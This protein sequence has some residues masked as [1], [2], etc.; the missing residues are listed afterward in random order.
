MSD[1]YG[2]PKPEPKHKRPPT[3]LKA[4]RRRKPKVSI[5]GLAPLTDWKE[6]T[7]RV[8][9]R[10]HGGSGHLRSGRF[11]LDQPGL[12][13]RCGKTRASEAHHRKLVSEGGPDV[14]SN[15]AALC[16]QCHSW[17]H[18]HPSAA[19]KGGWI[20]TAWADWEV[21]ALLLWDGSMVLLDDSACYSFI[22]WP[23]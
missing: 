15:L 6:L 8:L 4:K 13:E 3:P 16:R 11:I 17:C 19:R 10:P 18:T 2:Y 7:A 23:P 1:R 12:C 21:K 5:A 22:G 20:V 9:A 14:A